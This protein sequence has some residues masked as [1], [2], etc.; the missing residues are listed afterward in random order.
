MCARALTVQALLTD[1]FA[2]LLLG[3]AFWGQRSRTDS[4]F[5]PFN[6]STKRQLGVERC[7]SAAVTRPGLF[8]AFRHF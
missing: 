6:M 1:V 3:P 8:G 7:N 5:T 4:L 2:D